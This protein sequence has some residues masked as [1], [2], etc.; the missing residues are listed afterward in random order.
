MTRFLLLSVMALAAS[1]SL[2]QQATT[3]LSSKVMG[4]RELPRVL[5]IVPWRQPG[6]MQ[7]DWQPEAGIAQELFQPL[8]RDE[9]LRRLQYQTLTD[10]AQ[11]SVSHE[12]DN[13]DQ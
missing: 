4:N 11:H 13:S 8:R 6:E 12:T 1:A 9:Y 7:F 5:Y 2:A 10:E 3:T